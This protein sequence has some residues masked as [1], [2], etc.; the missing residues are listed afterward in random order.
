MEWV[1]FVNR[2]SSDKLEPWLAFLHGAMV[3]FI[4]GLGMAV[5]FLP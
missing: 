2:C 1:K 3:T 5:R 4:D